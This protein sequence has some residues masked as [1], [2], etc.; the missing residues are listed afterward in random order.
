MNVRGE[1]LI[2][3]GRGKQKDRFDKNSVGLYEIMKRLKHKQRNS[4]VKRFPHVQNRN[5]LSNII[6]NSVDCKG[7]V[8]EQT[9]TEWNRTAL[10]AAL[11][12]V[13]IPGI[14]RLR[15]NLFLLWA[16]MVPSTV[17]D[18]MDSGPTR[19]RMS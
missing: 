17:L 14:N 10:V 7:D 12:T 1:V 9:H 5:N 19:E 2:Q 4:I 8:G 11:S 3:M 18:S 13:L 16:Q 6:D 15:K